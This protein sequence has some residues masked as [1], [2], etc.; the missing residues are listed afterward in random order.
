[1]NSLPG[2][3]LFGWKASEGSLSEAEGD[4]PPRARG[5]Q[6]FAGR[7]PGSA[8]RWTPLFHRGKAVEPPGICVLSAGGLEAGRGA[9]LPGD[10]IVAVND[11][12]V[13][14]ELDFRF[15][16]QTS[17]LRLR[18]L[19]GQKGTVLTMRI[20]REDA[21]LLTFE[22]LRPA[23]CKNRCVFCFVDQL[24]PDLRPSLYFKD[25]DYRFSF[26][27]GNFVTL[28]TLT[29]A[30]L[31]RILQQ[32]MQPLYVSVHATEERVR[33]LLLGRNKSRDI[34]ETL[35]TLAAHGLTVHT[36]I[37]LCPGINDGDV[38]VRTLEDLAALYPSVASIAVVPVGLTKYR[39]EKGLTPL[40]VVTRKDAVRVL[41]VISKMAER[42]WK[43]FRDPLVHGADELYLKAGFRFPRPDN[44]GDFP[45]W[46]NGVGI[47]ASFDAI[48][49]RQ[50]TKRTSFSLRGLG[51][52][53]AAATGELAF[54]HVRRYL[55]WLERSRGIRIDLV[56]VRNRFFGRRVGVAGLVTG[57]DLIRQIKEA[58]LGGRILLIPAVMLDREQRRFL[59]DVTL[60]DVERETRCSVWAF[61]A[62]PEGLEAALAEIFRDGNAKVVHTKAVQAVDR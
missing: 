14:D 11:R 17:W 49:R 59:D 53:I 56:P 21:S 37:V 29:D 41:G 54:S 20:R 57:R 5:G 43:R 40:R 12:E 55:D 31:H 27:Y 34:L 23:R 22:P 2:K 1:M 48:W 60:A 42:Y 4:E 13:R 36:Q 18:V 52:P 47:V 25:E 39:K 10:R 51:R 3:D 28:S 33:N 15:Y 24:P 50:R 9:L 26:L 35:G 62:D 6:T 16:G 8:G 61:R 38:L 7:K 58:R 30:E 32:R 45:Q 44:Y 19:R 46:E